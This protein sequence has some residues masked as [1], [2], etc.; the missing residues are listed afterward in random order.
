VGWR[1]GH[2]LLG[3]SDERCG[4]RRHDPAARRA[5]HAAAATDVAPA[6][7]A[8]VARPIEVGAAPTGPRPANTSPLEEIC[9]PLRVLSAED[10]RRHL[11]YDV[12][13]PLVRD[14]MIALSKG[15]TQQF[16]RQIMMRRG[17]RGMFGMMGGEM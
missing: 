6:H 7:D 16:L 13:V 5:G 4:V 14:A 9:M 11:T 10:V 15:T 8:G 2:V 1:R 3:R 17:G 12:C